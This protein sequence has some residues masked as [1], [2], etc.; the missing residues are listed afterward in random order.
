[1]PSPPHPAGGHSLGAALMLQP[2]LY[3]SPLRQ[4]VPSP[5]PS[6]SE[7]AARPVLVSVPGGLCHVG[8]ALPHAWELSELSDPAHLRCDSSPVEGGAD[9]PRESGRERSLNSK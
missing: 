5:L 2:P 1:M 4:R 7:R 8:P 9:V 6:A 3:S